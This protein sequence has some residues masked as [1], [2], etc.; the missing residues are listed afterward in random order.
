MLKSSYR[1]LFYTFIL[2]LIID[3]G[4]CDNENE[5]NII[6]IPFKSYFPKYEFMNENKNLITSWVRRKFYLGIEN[7]SGQK[8]QMILNNEEPQMHIREHVSLIESDEIY[9]EPYNKNESDICTFNFKE[10]NTY[11]FTSAFNY[12]FHSIPNSCLAKEKMYF[13]T[14]LNLK[15]KKSFDI[16]FIHSSNETHIC[17]FSG[18][19][20]TD[21]SDAKNI[22]LLYQ[23]KHLINSNKYSWTLKFN[24]PDEGYFIFGDIIN[25]NKLKFYNDN[26]EENF[27]P[28]YVQTVSLSRIYWKLPVEK[29]IFDDYI[30]NLESKYSLID[31]EMRYI[32]VPKEYFYE[33]KKKYLLTNENITDS[34]KKFICFDEETEFFF[35]SV[36]CDKKEYLALTDNYKKLPTLNIYHHELDIIFSPK[37]LF[38]EKGDKIFFFIAYSTHDYEGEWH[39]GNIFL[40]K[41]ITVF[42]NEAKQLNILKRSDKDNSDTDTDSDSKSDTD[43]DTDKK[44]ET[45]N[46]EENSN[47]SINDSSKIIII[48][49]LVFIITAIIFGLIGIKYGKKYYQNRKKK[50]N[51]LNEDYDYSPQSINNE[52]NIE[53]PL[54]YQKN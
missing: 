11:Q 26:N 3:L 5:G 27:I 19:Q 1:F 49:I 47:N 52:Q 37:E 42:N 13:Y 48:I 7:E 34:E 22:N 46:D 24:S 23:L 6:I 30:I 20:L 53:N 33:I 4:N 41:Y 45:K 44:K 15:E 38:L 29:V 12:K 14:D 16:N 18:L 9:Y 51:E 32:T 28:F 39:I 25:N 31:F 2:T 35:H 21:S 10:S 54:I 8:L 50:A 36:Y 43:N 40:E 17:F